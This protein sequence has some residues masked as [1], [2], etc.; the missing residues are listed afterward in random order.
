MKNAN[1]KNL[2]KTFGLAGL[3]ILFGMMAWAGVAAAQDLPSAA[4][5]ASLF[6]T[7]SGDSYSSIFLNQIFGP[8]FPTPGNEGLP[9]VFSSIIGYFNVIMLVVGGI[10]FFYN[11]SVGILQ[12]AHEGSVLGQRWSS[13]WAPL[14]VIFAVGL[15]VPVPNLGGYN[16]AQAGIAY[17]VRGATNI[18]SSVWVTSA[19][20][21]MTNKV[22]VTT[23]PARLDPGLIK[24]IFDN[25]A[26]EAV[27]EYQFSQASGSSGE[28][29]LRIEYVSLSP[30]DI[31]ERSQWEKWGWASFS[32]ELTRQSQVVGGD[33]P[34]AGICGSYTTPEMPEFIVKAL[35][36]AEANEI[37]IADSNVEALIAAFQAAHLDA[38]DVLRSK[39]NEGLRGNGNEVLMQ[40]ADA[41][42]PL[43]DLTPT[44]VG[45]IEAANMTLEE[46]VKNVLSIASGQAPQDGEE[47]T[48]RVEMHGQKARDAMLNRIRGNCVEAEG[49]ATKCYGEGWIGA[50]SWYMMMARINNEISSLT[51]A[52]A[53][54]TGPDDS[55]GAYILTQDMPSEG[56]F[57]GYQD[58][59]YAAIEEQNLLTA[60]FNEAFE[61]SAVGLATF[62]FSLSTEQLE[63]LNET[64]EP[65][66]IL[67]S[68]P[69]LDWDMTSLMHGWLAITSPSYWGSDPMMG[70]TSIGQSMLNA[71]T[72]LFG[73]G[74]L[75]G[76]EIK[77]LGTGVSIPTGIAVMLLAPTTAL[78][79]GG[80][81]LAFV[82]PLTPFIFWIMAVSGYFLLVVEAVIAVNLWAI[83]HMRMDGEGIS[84]EGGRNGWLMIL[85]LLMTPVL[86]VFGF[87]VGMTLF[88]ITTALMDA[89]IYQAV[90]GIIGAG[91]FVTLWAMVIYTM[92]TAMVYMMVL[93]R[94]FSLVADLPGR[95]LRWIN[96]NVDLG[97]DTKT[98]RM[99]AAAGA[100]GLGYAARSMIGSSQ[101]PKNSGVIGVGSKMGGVARAGFNYFRPKNQVTGSSDGPRPSA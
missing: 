3:A 39:I 61:N 23:S 4:D 92:T 7:E 2:S 8:L 82:L 36:E 68:I 43:P 27:A 22:A 29:P 21:I 98:A 14:R 81:T 87:L 70:I 26:C 15:M 35:Y 76:A 67:S 37:T 99:A 44:I 90:S 73:I 88:R 17:L 9:T 96:S 16:L 33:D 5:T 65:D 86:M 89:G 75:S 63:N 11:V 41:S 50:G 20:L 66:S 55:R 85:A 95:V 71:G 84:G 42:A 62:G 45:A 93:E 1:V 40:I 28:Q 48:L 49:T 10:L 59:S 12:S 31:G 94:S 34:R 38:L 69:G 60:R 77:V 18:A 97:V 30:E 56:W 101:D 19:E 83:G 74:L 53:T 58:A 64:T 32:Y 57:S 78:I 13:L 79:A 91:P 46:G 47:G 24:T 52:T 54:A 6:G 25:A 51:R 80:G 72:A 100:G